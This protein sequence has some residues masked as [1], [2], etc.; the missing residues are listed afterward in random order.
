[1]RA[2]ERRYWTRSPP[3]GSMKLVPRPS[4][5]SPVNRAPSAGTWKAM[6][7]LVCPGVC[8]AMR[9]TPSG[10]HR[11]S[12]AQVLGAREPERVAAAR[13]TRAANAAA[14]GAWSGWSCVTS[15][16]ATC[17][18][19]G[20][21]ATS[22]RCA[23]SSGPGSITTTGCRALRAHDPRVRAL[24]RVRARVRGEHAHDRAA[25]L[26]PPRRPSEEAAR[27]R[28]RAARGSRT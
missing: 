13:S 24:E 27:P 9:V 2:S 18:P 12:V 19:A 1:M 26:S 23:G 10:A 21:L 4:T 20:T 8:T 28:R 7:S 5:A 3:G 17:E 15:T 22:S 16:A 6:W 11:L 14:P 25:R